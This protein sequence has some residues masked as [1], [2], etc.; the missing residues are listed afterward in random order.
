MAA[1]SFLDPRLDMVWRK[2]MASCQ[3]AGQI[4]GLFEKKNLPAKPRATLAPVTGPIRPTRK[5]IQNSLAN[6]RAWLGARRRSL[7]LVTLVL[8]FAWQYALLISVHF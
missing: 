6:E 3:P 7:I 4:E 5:A 8:P 1:E 2:R